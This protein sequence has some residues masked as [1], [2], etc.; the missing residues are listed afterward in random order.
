[1]P[2][3]CALSGKSVVHGGYGGNP[4]NVPM[5]IERFVPMLGFYN[6]PVERL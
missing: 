6:V 5:D 3:R 1:M 4:D 2:R